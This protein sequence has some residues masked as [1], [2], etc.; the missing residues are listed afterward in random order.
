M[1]L[2]GPLEKVLIGHFSAWSASMTVP[3]FWVRNKE[4]VSPSDIMANLKAR[5]VRLA[6]FKMEVFKM[7]AFS[8]SR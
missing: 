2:V 1:E 4:H 8:L 3:S 6:N 7:V 5:I